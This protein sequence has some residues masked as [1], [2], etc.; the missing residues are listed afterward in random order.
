MVYSFDGR[1]SVMFG[2]HTHVPTADEEILPRGSGYITDLG[3]C[4]PKNGIL[5]TDR[6]AVIRKFRTMLPT[7]FS[8]AEGETV[9]MGAIFDVDTDSG[10]VRDVRRIRF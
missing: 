8:V 3:M 6:D 7:A 10:R 9:A 1:I 4:G 2:T 5:G